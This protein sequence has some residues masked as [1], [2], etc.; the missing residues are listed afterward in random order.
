VHLIFLINDHIRYPQNGWELTPRGRFKWRVSKK[1]HNNYN[2]DDNRRKQGEWLCRQ[3]NYL[4]EG[5]SRV[6]VAKVWSSEMI[7]YAAKWPRALICFPQKG[8]LDDSTE[9][10]VST[11]GGQWR[12]YWAIAPSLPPEFSSYA[13]IPS[14]F[15]ILC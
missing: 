9:Q 14:G 1:N 10:A 2:S 6:R 4:D 3:L 12:R 8:W 5:K 11:G 13:F 7:Q 15:H